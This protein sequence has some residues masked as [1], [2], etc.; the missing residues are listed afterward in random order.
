MP[1]RTE[2]AAARLELIAPRSLAPGA[3]TQLRLIVHRLDGFSQDVSTAQFSSNSPDTLRTSVDGMAGGVALGDGFVM[4]R[5]ESLT[6]TRE[7]VVV[8]DGTYRVV[9]RVLLGRRP[10]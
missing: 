4:A 1:P 7:I 9:G 10:A 3:T 5:F 2:Q 8:P 6:V